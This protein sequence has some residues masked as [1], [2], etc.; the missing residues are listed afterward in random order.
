M[1]DTSHD[2]RTLNS[3]IASIIDSIDGYT[4]SAKDADSGRFASIFNDRAAERR[5]VLTRLQAEVVRLGG[6]P[7]DDGT[8]AAAA[9]RGFI[10]LKSAVTGR[11]DKAV[12]NEVERG[13]DHL[14]E[15]F[16][17]ALADSDLSPQ[18]KAVVQE[19]YTSVRQGHDQMSALK[20]SMAAH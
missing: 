5:Q 6:N 2:I 8:T 14:K 18:V 10:N 3:L 12:I 7:E 19:C 4:E 9:H 1:V 11:D 20:H 15:K 17:D 16:E 13:E